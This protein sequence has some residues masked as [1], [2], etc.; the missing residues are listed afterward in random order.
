MIESFFEDIPVLDPSKTEINKIFE[1][2]GFQY[3]RN[4]ILTTIKN[5]PLSAKFKIIKDVDKDTLTRFNTFQGTKAVHTLSYMRKIP[6]RKKDLTQID[7][8]VLMLRCINVICAKNDYY[9]EKRKK[10]IRVVK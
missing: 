9:K 3:Y 1:S 7:E 2:K 4:E 6:S 8:I 10:I 5:L